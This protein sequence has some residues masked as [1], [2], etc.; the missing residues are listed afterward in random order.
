MLKLNAKSHGLLAIAAAFAVAGAPM[1]AQAYEFTPE[2]SA[3]WVGIARSLTLAIDS[4]YEQTG[5][6]KGINAFAATHASIVKKITSIKGWAWQAHYQICFGLSLD[7]SHKGAKCKAYKTAIGE[8]AKAMPGKDP[9]DAVAA[10]TM[11]KESLGSML[12]ELQEA[13]LC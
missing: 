2:G 3:N 11:L 8:L 10:A 13:K 1:A 5:V 12:A 6:C 9:A 7:A 4:G